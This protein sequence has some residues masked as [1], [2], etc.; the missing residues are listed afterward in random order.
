VP[1]RTNVHNKTMEHLHPSFYILGE[2]S[3]KTDFSRSELST[4]EN[5][6]STY[7]NLVMSAK[8]REQ[9]SWH[10]EN[11]HFSMLIDVKIFL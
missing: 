5:A 11:G 7:V 3:I 6:V 1:V 8:N 10:L 2:N 4:L 9:Q